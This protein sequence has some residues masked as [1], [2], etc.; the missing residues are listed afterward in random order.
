MSTSLNS[1][2]V[3]FATCFAYS[4]TVAGSAV[5]SPCSSASSRCPRITSGGT[6][7]PRSIAFL[8]CDSCLPANARSSGV[9]T[10]N[11]QG[12]FLSAVCD[13]VKEWSTS[14]DRD[15]KRI[16]TVWPEGETFSTSYTPPGAMSLPLCEETTFIPGFNSDRSTVW[17]AP[18]AFLTWALNCCSVIWWGGFRESWISRIFSR[19]PFFG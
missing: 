6:G 12:S 7:S 1:S 3:M 16:V 9:A 4:C 19:P 18:I 10:W 2:G 11:F 13:K 17:R 15:L 14:P 5:G 8:T